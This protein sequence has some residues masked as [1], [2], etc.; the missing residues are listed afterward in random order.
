MLARTPPKEQAPKGVDYAELLRLP[1]KPPSVIEA[2]KALDQATTE[3]QSAQEV[4]AQALRQFRGMVP[5]QLPTVSAREVD[6]LGDT[7]TAKVAAEAAAMATRDAERSA[8]DASIRS[9]IDRGLDTLRDEILKVADRFDELLAHG[10]M[11][12][13]SA[14]AARF[15]LHDPFPLRCRE[16]QNSIAATIRLNASKR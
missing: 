13:A 4:Q 16:M 15:N 3:R 10:T 8:F 12:H 1:P 6:E 11:L 7:L 14:A 2:E 5:G 9:Q